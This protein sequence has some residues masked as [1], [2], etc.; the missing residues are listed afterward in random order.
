[1]ITTTNSARIESYCK[2]KFVTV[3]FGSACTGTYIYHIDH[4]GKITTKSMS[5]PQFN[6]YS[7]INTH[8]LKYIS[9]SNMKD[10]G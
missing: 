9:Q 10:N 4:D 5:R 8:I 7:T 6:V 3:F 1:V 2:N